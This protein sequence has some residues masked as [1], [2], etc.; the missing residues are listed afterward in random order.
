MFVEKI[1]LLKNLQ[2]DLMI[3]EHRLFFYIY[4]MYV[5]YNLS[6]IS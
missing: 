3:H 1:N 4:L 6:F 2:A 5:T